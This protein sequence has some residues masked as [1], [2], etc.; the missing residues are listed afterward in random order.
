MCIIFS[1]LML[2]YILSVG[3]HVG[4]QDLGQQNPGGIHGGIHVGGI[5]TTIMNC[6]KVGS[7]AGF[8][9]GLAGSRPGLWIASGR[10]PGGIPPEAFYS[11]GQ[12][13]T[14]D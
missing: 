14:W 4:C 6:P 8:Y 13:P 11:P 5:P 1:I 9:P 3:S 12:D 2:G 7:Q 10:I